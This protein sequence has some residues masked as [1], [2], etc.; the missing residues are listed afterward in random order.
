MRS[1]RARNTSSANCNCLAHICGRQ[2]CG[3]QKRVLESSDSHPMIVQFCCGE[4][5]RT[6]SSVSLAQ[7]FP[8]P[9]RRY[10]ARSGCQHMC[11]ANV[12]RASRASST[13]ES[14][15]SCQ[16]KCRDAVHTS[17]CL[18]LFEGHCCRSSD[19]DARS[20]PARIVVSGNYSGQ[21]TVKECPA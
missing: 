19:L 9:S 2:W 10:H 7:K 3:K 14:E 18:L 21:S 1:N 8:S 6:A 17:P 16:L 11:T 20:R 13:I 5:P 12:Q 4:I 15:N